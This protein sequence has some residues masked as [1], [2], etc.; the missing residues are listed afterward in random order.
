[1]ADAD[2]ICCATTSTR[3]AFSRVDVKT[4][5]HINA[6]GAS[7]ASMC[8]IHPD[9]LANARIVAVD[10]VDGALEEAGDVIQAIEAG[11]ISVDLLRELGS[12]L[13]DSTQ[14]AEVGLTVFKSVGIAQH[15]IGQSHASPAS[16]PGIFRACSHSISMRRRTTRC[17][18]GVA[19]ASTRSGSCRR[20]CRAAQV[21]ER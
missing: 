18:E 8:E 10:Q 7:T 13:A 6:I 14:R 20:P 9:V 11:A 15:R 21:A 5:V 4:D 17:V 12:L 1:V 3:P 19:R 16:A 2:V